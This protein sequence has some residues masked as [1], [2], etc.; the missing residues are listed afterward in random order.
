MGW[1]QSP[2]LSTAATETVTD[3]ANHHLKQRRPNH[4]HRL[5]QVSETAPAVQFPEPPT[6]GPTRIPTQGP[7]PVLVRQRL[8][9]GHPVPVKKWDVYV[10]YFIGLG[11]G[12]P[13]HRQHVKRALL[14]TLDTVFWRLSP[15]D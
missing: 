11:Q 4:P 8:Y 2:P 12:G 7:L 14:S 3:L 13:R 5:D 1:S 6:T 9:S 10:D 15:I